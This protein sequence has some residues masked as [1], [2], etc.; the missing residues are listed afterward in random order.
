MISRI[1]FITTF[2][3]TSTLFGQKN[4]P[5]TFDG[6][7]IG[8]EAG[9]Q[10]LYGGA[11]VDDVETIGDGNV[12]IFGGLI[13][14]RNS[15]ENRL[16]LGVELQVNQPFGE[17]TNSEN[18]DG[19]IVEYE[20]DLQT[21]LQFNF[22]LTFGSAQKSLIYGY[23]AVNQTRFNIEITGP[24]GHDSQS[25]F[26][27]FGRVGIAYEYNFFNSFSA[28]AMLGTSMDGLEGTNNGLDTKISVIYT[29]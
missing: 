4:E 8:V 17:F 3:I 23:F 19:S 6:F 14:W 2:L 9:N 29:L 22:G 16:N 26:E 5:T 20:I 11:Q 25:D 28:R 13:G 27:N 1:L 7:F 12:F 10:Y 21:A 15:F 18:P 24:D